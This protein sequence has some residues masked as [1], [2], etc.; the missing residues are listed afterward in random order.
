MGLQG[1]S[2]RLPRCSGAYCVLLLL[3]ARIGNQDEA[4]AVRHASIV[5]E[6]R[7]EGFQRCRRKGE[8]AGGGAPGGRWQLPALVSACSGSSLRDSG[9]VAGAFTWIIGEQSIAK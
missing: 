7:A 6:R 1:L 9:A 5:E 2:G 3:A 8:V 4:C